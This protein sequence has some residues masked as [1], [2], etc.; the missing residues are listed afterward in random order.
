MTSPPQAELH[1]STL[2]IDG[3]PVDA[4][5]GR[6]Y[7]I[8]NPARPT[9]LVGHAALGTVEDVDQ[10]FQ[11]AQRALPK[12]S[13]LSCAERA[14]YLR[15][16]A[17]HLT[18]DSA[19]LERRTTLF[20]REHGKILKEAAIEMTRLGTRFTDVAA[21]ATQLAQEPQLP[22]P[23][24]DTV[25][26]RKPRG[27]ALLIVPW[28]WPLSILG[29][30]LPQ[31]LLAGSTVVIKLPQQSAMAPA[32]TV[33]LMAQMLPPGVINLITGEAA[34]IGDAMLTH[35]LAATINFTGSVEVGKH[36]M[37]KAA[38]R[39][40]PVTLELGGNDAALVLQDADLN[41]AAFMRMYQGAFM[42]SG[43]ICMAMKRLYVHR[44]RFDEVVDGL[45]AI[46]SKQVVGDGLRPETTM[47]PLNNQ[48]QLKVV[49]DMIE[50]ARL[51]GAS[52]QELGVI[53]D[54]KGYREGYF[55]RPTL[56]LGPSHS[57]DVVREEQF[58][59]ALPIMPFETEEQGIGFA[60][61]SRF[62]LCS[63]VWSADPERA[64]SVARQLEAGY[65]YLNGHGPLAQDNRA[66]FGGFKHSG[67]GRNLGFEGIEGFLSPQSIS[68]PAGWLG[69]Q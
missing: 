64:M 34:E 41:E 15:R 38:Q 14:G 43:Q 49:Q 8:H 2:Y 62:A 4:R 46:A 68:A 69:K 22:G 63:S 55:Q 66:P 25:I 65:T 28:N 44:S 42:T 52:V 16:I 31:A 26:T 27:V 24:F 39:L 1:K 57:L 17:E 45:S 37:Q 30:K 40:T 50:Q 48:R 11:A 56:V 20:T 67:F 5:G 29:A 61:D 59:P 3:R 7:P 23:P 53:P 54:M 36:V 13:R 6:T 9:E 60:N 35:P 58:G 19:N 18:A 51:Q 21:Y 12:W 47:G 32:Q 33:A 10:A